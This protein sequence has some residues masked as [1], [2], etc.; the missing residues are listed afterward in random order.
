MLSVLA[1]SLEVSVMTAQCTR[2]KTPFPKLRLVYESVAM[3]SEF[4]WSILVLKYL[5][6]GSRAESPGS[7]QAEANVF[8][9]WTPRE[10][11]I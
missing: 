5:G 11:S 2:R 4:T 10:A 6:S 9:V 3:D 7:M 8:L 1:T